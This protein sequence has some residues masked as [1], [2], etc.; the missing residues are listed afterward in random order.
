MGLAGVF[1]NSRLLGIITD[2]DLRRALERGGDILN[3]KSSELMTK[4]PKVVHGDVLAETALRVMEEHSITAL[5]V[6]DAFGEVAG[7]LHMH[8][9]LKAGVV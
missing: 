8:D 1:D 7:V 2:G 3:M 6:T 9:L 4:N 5:F